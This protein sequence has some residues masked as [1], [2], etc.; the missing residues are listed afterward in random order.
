MKKKKEQLI[1][2]KPR[3]FHVYTRIP[4]KGKVCRQPAKQ[5][6]K[7]S[8][9]ALPQKM[10]SFRVSPTR[11]DLQG[12]NV[13]NKNKHQQEQPPNCQ[14]HWFFLQPLQGLK[15]T[16]IPA[17]PLGKQLSAFASLGTFLGCLSN[18]LVRGWLASPLG[19]WIVK[20]TCSQTKSTRPGWPDGTFL[21]KE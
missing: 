18:D 13:L 9:V 5:T 8:Y 15:L 6:M 7:W 1:L 14:L 2:Q 10:S 19:Q 12:S 21:T 3:Q 17:C 11:C 16:W 4:N 20:V